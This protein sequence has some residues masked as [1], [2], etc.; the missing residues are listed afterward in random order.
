MSNDHNEKV[1]YPMRGLPAC[2]KSYTARRLAGEEGVVFE[3]D[4]YFCTEVGDDP[5]RY[6]YAEALLPEARQWNLDRFL[7]ALAEQKSPIVVDRGNG[8]NAET[9][10]YAVAAVKHGYQVQLAEPESPW[11]QELRVLLK[12]K[13]HIADELFDHWAT[14]RAE[15]TRDTHRVPRSTIRRWMICWRDGITVRDILE[16]D[17]A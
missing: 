6:D 15:A 1:V 11:W 2:G 8:L 4:Q 13:Q 3:T 7:R 12:Y 10:V 14:Q 17:G 9:R 16:Y 5:A